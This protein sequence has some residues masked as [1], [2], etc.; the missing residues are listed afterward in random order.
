MEH[1]IRLNEELLQ[2]WLELFSTTNI[3]V[4]IIHCLWCTGCS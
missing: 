2:S 3:I 4:H 1:I